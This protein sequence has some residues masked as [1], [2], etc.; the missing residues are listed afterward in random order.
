MS[1]PET[2]TRDE[3]TEACH[4]LNELRFV[5]R[6]EVRKLTGWSDPTLWRRIRD[7]LFPRPFKDCGRD[8]WHYKDV[9]KALEDAASIV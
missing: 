5:R 1:T 8:A 4:S 6:R 3:Q 2:E 9:R 7:G